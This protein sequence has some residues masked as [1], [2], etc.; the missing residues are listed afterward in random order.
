[1]Q[2]VCTFAFY[3]LL[4]PGTTFSTI[5][6][7]DKYQQAEN[8]DAAAKDELCECPEKHPFFLLKVFKNQ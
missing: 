5:L 6:P 4:F 1:M 3:G 2:P 7:A 8:N